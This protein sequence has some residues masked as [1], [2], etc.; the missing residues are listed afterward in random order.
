MK[1]I[2]EISKNSNLKYE[3]DE[4]TNQLVLDRV[5]RN[6]NSF[7]YNYGFIPKTLAPDGDPIDILLLSSHS[8]VPGCAVDIRILGGIETYDEKGQD[9]KIVCVLDSKIDT[10]YDHIKGIHEL[11]ESEMKQILYFLNHYKDGEVNKFV[12]VGEIYN[13]TTAMDFIREYSV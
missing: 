2:I 9:D 8:L 13:H 1:V 11:P 4:L 6:T 10:E 5:L 3:Y 7:P 12:K